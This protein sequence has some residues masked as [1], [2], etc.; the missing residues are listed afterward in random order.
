[1]DPSRHTIGQNFISSRVTVTVYI[2]VVHSE[3]RPEG[4]DQKVAGILDQVAQRRRLFARPLVALEISTYYVLLTGCLSH[5]Q[6]N[7]YTNMASLKVANELDNV[8]VRTQGDRLPLAATT[9][10]ISL[11][12]YRQYSVGDAMKMQIA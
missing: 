12:Y 1:M 3:I 9:R 5:D 7:L 6:L 4:I 8:D 2:A 10:S 11:S